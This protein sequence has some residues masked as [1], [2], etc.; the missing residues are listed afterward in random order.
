MS[1]SNS[2]RL[3]RTDAAFPETVWP[4]NQELNELCKL[5]W[6][7][8][9]AFLRRAGHPP[10]DARDL[11]QGLFVHLLQKDRLLR[12]S[13][14]KGRFRTFLLGCLK[15]YLRNER[16]KLL[17]DKRGGGFVPVPIDTAVAEQTVGLA[18]SRTPTPDEAYDRQ[19][20]RSLMANVVKSLR[21]EYATSGHADRFEILYPFLTD[22]AD[23]GDYA[24]AAAKL[25][26][27]DGAA[28]KAAHALRERFSAVRR[29]EI[30]RTAAEADI[31][32]ETRFLARV[33]RKR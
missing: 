25:H 15:N 19:W 2:N 23:R 6:P 16:D 12:A 4:L 17:T 7:P 1:D 31:E 26:I 14:E 30:G 11:A 33:V 22:E 18:D 13:P 21:D 8:V 3:D 9:Y 29:A 20:A 32:E 28:R 27:S 5:Y 10:E 24:N